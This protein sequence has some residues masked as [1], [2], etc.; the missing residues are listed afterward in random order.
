LTD[1]PPAQAKRLA[2]LDC[3]DFTSAPWVTGSARSQRRVTMVSSAGLAAPGG[4]PFRGRDA[5]YRAIPADTKPEDL[6]IIH[7]SINFDHDRLGGGDPLFVYGRH[8]PGADKA[9]CPRIGRRLKAD[10]ADD[11]ILPP[12]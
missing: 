9:S 7:I 8:R 4:T 5:D 3:P 2:E 6:L 1:L 11:V 12:V 10:A